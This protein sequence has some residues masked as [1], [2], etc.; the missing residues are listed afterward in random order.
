[1]FTAYEM[2]YP[3]CVGKIYGGN[4]ASTVAENLT[5]E[6][7][8]GIAVDEKPAEARRKFEQLIHQTARVDPWLRQNPPIIEWWGGQFAPA[9]IRTNHPIIKTLGEAFTQVTN[10]E[11]TLQGMTYGAD[12][13]LLVNDGGIPTVMFGA[14]DVRK[15]HQFDENVPLDELKT[16][17][18]TI[19]LTILHFCGV[20]DSAIINQ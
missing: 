3:I 20:Q 8:Y 10:Q 7:R 5:F 4:W 14:G 2:P 12:M 11:P 9:A 1:M 16:V 13:R 15:A 6:G 17:V 19:A 18:K